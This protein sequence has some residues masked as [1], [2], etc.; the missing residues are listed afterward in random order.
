MAEGIIDVDQARRIVSF[1]AAHAGPRST[2]LAEVLG[3]LGAA[4]VVA[5]LAALMGDRWSDIPLAGQ[6]AIVAMA[7]AVGAVTGAVARRREAAAFTRMAS[8][9]W[10]AT[11]GGVAGLTVLVASDGL[12]L[13]DEVTLVCVLA[14]AAA[15]AVAFY[16]LL[17]GWLQMIA[18]VGTTTG[19]V[20]A[21][22]NL[23]GVDFSPVY[24]FVLLAIGTTWVLQAFRPLLGPASAATI[25]G[26]V[27]FFIGSAAISGEWTIAGLALLGVG[28]IAM[29]VSSVLTRNILFLVLGALGLFQSLPRL[30]V[31]LF[32]ESIGAALALLV[33][34]AVIIVVAL[35]LRRPGGGPQPPGDGHTAPVGVTRSAAS[36]V[37]EAL[38]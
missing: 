20:A 11:V 24:G 23:A 4:L 27:A 14:A 22:L 19:L 10:L 25:A 34:G 8:L 38:R 12:D 6:I 9:L 5:A 16:V 1:E 3:Y 18:L 17:P 26:A 37:Q 2:L 31:E 32:G 30:A 29:L 33:A 35:R 7:T 15:A 13:S 36:P 28:A 21:V